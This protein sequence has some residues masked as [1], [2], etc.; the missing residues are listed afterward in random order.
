LRE[1]RLKQEWFREGTIRKGEAGD[2][3]IKEGVIEST[4]VPCELIYQG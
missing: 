3:V 1:A 4:R 2:G